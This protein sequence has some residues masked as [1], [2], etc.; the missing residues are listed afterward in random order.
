MGWDIHVACQ[1]TDKDGNVCVGDDYIATFTIDGKS[2]YHISEPLFEH[3]NYN[4]FRP[5]ANAHNT[6]KCID[7][8]RKYWDEF[9]EKT[10]CEHGASSQK[11][12]RD[13][14]YPETIDPTDIVNAYR[15][16]QENECIFLLDHLQNKIP[17]LITAVIKECVLEHSYESETYA[18][19]LADLG[20]FCNN[21]PAYKMLETFYRKA[22][23]R[24]NRCN[25]YHR[26]QKGCDI[27]RANFMI[28]YGFDY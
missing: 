25:Q 7:Q 4:L 16:R 26:L 3:R 17:T 6:T 21:H 27:G 19:S 8:E 20:D 18:I 1:Y 24:Y 28:F 14:F 12:W 15:V 10:W 9:E 22:N 23:D 11:R 5:L 2:E 13:E